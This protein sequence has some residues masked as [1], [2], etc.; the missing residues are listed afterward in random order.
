MCPDDI[1]ETARQIRGAA[2]YVLQNYRCVP[3][4]DP[5]LEAQQA[6]SDDLLRQLASEIR[7][8]GI[9]RRCILRGFE[10]DDP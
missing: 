5:S 6:Y 10:S 2:V 9:V 7:R 4:F 1:K 3:G 8:E